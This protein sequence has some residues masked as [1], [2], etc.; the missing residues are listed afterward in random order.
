VSGL[1]ESWERR[2]LGTI[3][4]Y[5]NGR[6]F[7]PTEWGCSGRPIIRIQ[8]LTGSTSTVNYYDGPVDE[9]HL[10]RGGDLLISWAATL[11][12]YFYAGPE[13]AL[14]QH[15]F[16]VES[17]IDLRF[18]KY[19]VDH[20][21]G[22]MMQRT[23][24]SGM[25]HI[26]KGEFDALPVDIPPLDEQRRIVA[27]LEDH[28]SRLDAATASLA[29]ASRRTELLRRS[30]LSES[31]GLVGDGVQLADLVEGISAGKS[32]ATSGR[33]AADDEWG[34]IKVSAMT[35]GEFDPAENKSVSAVRADPRFEIKAGDLLVSRANTA[36]LVGASVMVHEVRPR[37]LLSDK[38]LRVTPKLGVSTEWLWRSLQAPSARKQISALATGTK[39]SMRNISQASLLR[40]RLRVA[41]AGEQET[42]LAVFQELASE[43]SRLR[44][45]VETQ[46]RRS[47]ALRRSLIAAAFRGD[48]TDERSVA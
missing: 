35:W 17:Q 29:A 18:H 31:F 34:I 38:S 15:I 9:R 14:N 13:G 41:D 2:T 4:R 25:V 3:G 23:H 10:V 44:S 37:L 24:G 42:A 28:L 47:V 26:T 33:P 8:N 7:K 36:E 5:I 43:E 12:A 16:K 48:L 32:H 19:L 22:E 11:G 45:T 30:A 40:L 46:A 6:A 21:L 20:K 39:D 1:P 27:I